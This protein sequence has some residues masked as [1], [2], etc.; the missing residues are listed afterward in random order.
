M[1]KLDKLCKNNKWDIQYDSLFDVNTN[2]LCMEI[3]IND[4]AGNEIWRER[5]SLD[6][7]FNDEFVYGKLISDLREEKL[8]VLLN[9]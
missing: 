2:N 1:N 7:S 9:G 6:F 3:T 5:L 8:N 4:K